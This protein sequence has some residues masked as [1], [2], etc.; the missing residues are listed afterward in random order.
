MVKAGC[1]YV[2]AVPEVTPESVDR[3]GVGV[4]VVDSEQFDH[5][6]LETGVCFP[7]G[8]LAG[9]IKMPPEHVM[10][11][12]NKEIKDD[13]T[14]VKTTVKEYMWH[15]EPLSAFAL[16]NVKERILDFHSNTTQLL[17][18]V[19]ESLKKANDSYNQY[20]PGS[21]DLVSTFFLGMCA[22]TLTV[23]SY[24]QRNCSSS[25]R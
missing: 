2:V 11:R 15:S 19:L 1:R 24:L 8:L 12:G 3:E 22:E 20:V 10:T 4:E 14:V 23:T 5:M 6:Q 25:W 16:R 17:F 21:E 7:G 9:G 18:D 13:G